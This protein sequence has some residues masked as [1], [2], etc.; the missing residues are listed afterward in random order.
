VDSG[1][2][3]RSKLPARADPTAG[4]RR[5]HPGYPGPSGVHWQRAK[6]WITS[7]DPAYARKRGPGSVDSHGS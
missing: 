2:G 4:Q 7:P 5:D 3:R 1:I 6:D